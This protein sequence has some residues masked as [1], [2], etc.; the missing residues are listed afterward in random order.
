MNKTI[1]KIERRP[2]ESFPDFTLRVYKLRFN[3]NVLSK[4][5]IGVRVNRKEGI[6]RFYFKRR[7]D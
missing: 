3:L 4:T 2:E 5:P 6:A 1:L 7:K